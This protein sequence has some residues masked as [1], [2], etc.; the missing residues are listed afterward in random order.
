[1]SRGNRANTALLGFLPKAFKVVI[2]SAPKRRRMRCFAAAF[3]Q[4]A[5]PYSSVPMPRADWS[6]KLPESIS[7]GRRKLRTLLDVSEF[8]LALPPE[9]Q[10]Q[11]RA[12]YVAELAMKAAEGRGDAAS[13][14]LVLQIAGLAR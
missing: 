12:L 2:A 3:G 6:Q 1:L 10:A 5:R 7:I 8:L 13:V 11:P 14:G 9:T 4:N